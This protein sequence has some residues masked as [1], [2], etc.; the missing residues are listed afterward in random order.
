[1]MRGNVVEAQLSRR[2][3]RH[4]RSQR[5]KQSRIKGERGE[6]AGGEIRRLEVETTCDEGRKND[7]IP[8]FN[9]KPSKGLRTGSRQSRCLQSDERRIER[10]A[11]SGC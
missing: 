8:N 7:R 9:F 3:P 2:G 4:D 5:R 1:M 11:K 10:K 6:K